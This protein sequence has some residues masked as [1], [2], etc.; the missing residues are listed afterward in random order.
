MRIDTWPLSQIDQAA[1][2]EEGRD[3]ARPLLVQNDGRLGY[4]VQAADARADHH[5][6]FDLLLV[7]L[8]GSSSASRQR[9]S[10][11]RDGVNDE[12]IDPSL[13]LRLHPLVGVEC[14]RPCRR[15]GEPASRSCRQNPTSR[16]PGS[17]PPRSR[18]RSDVPRLHRLR[19]RSGETMP[20]PVTTT[21]RIHRPR[22]AL[23]DQTAKAQSK[24][25][26]QKRHSQSSPAPL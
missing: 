17:V 8:V 3:A 12:I 2:N 9:L 18:R 26:R 19:S 11:R 25:P 13:F 23:R 21:L 20:R 22:F 15:R 14:A 1:G 10:R 6:G 16:N 5:A 7:G 24:I 4:A